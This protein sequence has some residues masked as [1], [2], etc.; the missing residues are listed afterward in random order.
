[1]STNDIVDRYKACPCGNGK[2]RITECPP[3]HPYSRSTQTWYTAE[4]MRNECIMKY[5]IDDARID[6]GRYLILK[7]NNQEEP[8]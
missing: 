5:Q 3:D 2:I 8:I 6:G 7:S 4:I 1:M